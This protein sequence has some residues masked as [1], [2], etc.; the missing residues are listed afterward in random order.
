LLYSSVK[1]EVAPI[2][3]FIPLRELSLS[4]V[5]T[6]TRIDPAKAGCAAASHM[7]F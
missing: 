1:I 6:I 7:I 2:I 3:D 4:F 5:E